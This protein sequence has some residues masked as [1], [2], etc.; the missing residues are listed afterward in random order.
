MNET[1]Q[2]HLSSL[3]KLKIRDF[4]KTLSARKGELEKKVKEN[5]K[6]KELLGQLFAYD[7]ILR[8]ADKK[9][10]VDTINIKM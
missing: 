5:P 6:D 9:L 7:E 8:I 1:L 10:N 3:F 4:K 2:T